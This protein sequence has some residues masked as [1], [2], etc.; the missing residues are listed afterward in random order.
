[1][2]RRPVVVIGLL[3]TKLDA[4][5]GAARWERWRPTVATCQHPELLVDRLE[6]LHGARHEALAAQVKGDV[7]SVSPETQVTLHPIAMPDPWD[8]EAVYDALL[9]YADAQ[10]FDPEANDYLVQITTGSHVAQI[11]LFLLTEARFL[12]G[13]LLQ[14]S[15][16][17]RGDR[18]V[19]GS[20][21]TIDLD[22]SRYDRIATRKAAQSADGVSFLKQG[23]ETRNAAFNGLM[24]E[25]ERVAGVSRAP[26]LLTGPTGAGKTRLARRI[27]ALKRDRNLVSGAFVELNCATLRGDGAMS[28]LFGHVR[29]SFT[30]AVGD[31][32]GLLRQADGGLLF[33]DEI[34][35]LGAD[36]QAML[37][38][39]VEERRFLP[40]GAD[41]EVESD[42]Q[43][44]AGTNRDLWAEVQAGRFRED[45]LARID[46]W[47][48]ALPPLRHRLEDLEP[49]LDFE[50][51]R[52]ARLEGRRVSFNGEARAAFLDFARGPEATWRANFRDLSAAVTRMATLAPGG[53]INEQTVRDERDRLLGRW[54]GAT[55]E[56]PARALL[57]ETLGEAG[58]ADLDRFDRVQLGDVL[59][60]CRAAPSLSE[61]GRRLFSVSRAKKRSV[62]DADR[63]RKYLARFDLKWQTLP[64]NYEAAESG[65][66][67]TV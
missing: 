26:L 12:P 63:L 27:Y 6:L 55:Q 35:E 8:F 56:D 67:E 65:V 16:P 17:R 53:R 11:C 39:A 20:F 44:I 38:R 61:A 36:E 46:L 29:G 49:N 18:G 14:V 37:L 40:M 33:L 15:P 48:W 62:N 21:A 42:F 59:R 5:K 58:V 50:L 64:W 4:G 9:A 45:L 13:R 10:D 30:G 22:L 25:I 31:R 1:M 34:G 51:E 23:I 54:N 60:V 19:A 7:Q 66:P 43:L 28:T 41:R 3:G 57:L 52:F 2:A 24:A 47:T 32:A